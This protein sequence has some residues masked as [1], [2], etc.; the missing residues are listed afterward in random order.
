M[1]LNT[2]PPPSNPRQRTTVYLACG[3]LISYAIILFFVPTPKLSQP[4]RIGFAAGN[5]IAVLWLLAR[6]S[7]APKK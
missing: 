1:S 5:L 7:N 4:V 3:L 2:Q 6:Q